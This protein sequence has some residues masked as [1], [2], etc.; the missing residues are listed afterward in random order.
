MLTPKRSFII[1]ECQSLGMSDESRRTS[2][3]DTGAAAI[4]ERPADDREKAPN[5]L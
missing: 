2:S 3:T 5:T 4:P 1:S